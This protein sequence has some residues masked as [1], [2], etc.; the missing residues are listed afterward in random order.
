MGKAQKLLSGGCHGSACVETSIQR[1]VNRTTVLKGRGGL[2]LSSVL[3]RRGPSPQKNLRVS[4][5]SG[6]GGGRPLPLEQCA[7]Q[8]AAQQAVP[9]GRLE[10]EE[11]GQHLWEAGW[12]AGWHAHDPECGAPTVWASGFQVEW[13]PDNRCGTEDA[14]LYFCK[15]SQ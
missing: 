7:T 3:E 10:G 15:C 12:E 11:G 1:A 2:D 6:Q 9:L 5:G 14:S 8:E 4:W 13:L